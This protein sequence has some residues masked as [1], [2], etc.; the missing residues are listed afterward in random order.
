M[1]INPAAAHSIAYLAPWTFKVSWQLQYKQLTCRWPIQKFCLSW[2]AGIIII[3][4]GHLLDACCSFACA[5]G[6]SLRES[7]INQVKRVKKELPQKEINRV[8]I[9]K[10]V[11]LKV[12]HATTTFWARMLTRKVFIVVEALERSS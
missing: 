8:K 9:M 2:H 3:I 7:I 5:R 10:N 6:S 1:I 12:K 4:R 11:A